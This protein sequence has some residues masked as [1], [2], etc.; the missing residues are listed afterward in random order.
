LQRLREEV[1]RAGYRGLVEVEIFSQNDWWR[2]PSAETLA[3]C[4]ERLQSC[5]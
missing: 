2:R 3:V 4:A 5:C 1:E